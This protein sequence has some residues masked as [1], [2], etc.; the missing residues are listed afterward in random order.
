MI[1][2][3]Y[4][5]LDTPRLHLRKIGMDD[6]QLY[7]TRLGS[8]REVTKYMFFQ[9]HKDISESVASIEKAL[10]RY[11][12][13]RNYRW[14]IT[15]RE[16]DNIIGVIDLLKFDEEANSCSFAYMLGQDFWGKGYGTEALNAVMEFAFTKMEIAKIEAEH[17]GANIASGAVMR[18][19]GM[20]YQG[21]VPGKYE[22]DGIVYDAPQYI[23]TREQW[24]L[25]RKETGGKP[26]V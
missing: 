23:M 5:E 15:L 9:T 4:E 7:Y 14:A 25:K 2:A 21:T 12:T 11:E 17:F 19:A 3:A 6:L 13:G 26:F 22:K 20:I 24:I 10:K 8:S 1:Y 16:D 18:K